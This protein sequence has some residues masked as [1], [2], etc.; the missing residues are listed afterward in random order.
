MKRNESQM[1]ESNNIVVVLFVN[2]NFGRCLRKINNLEKIMIGNE[3]MVDVCFSP[4][5][6]F[7][8]HL[9]LHH[10]HRSRLN[11]LRSLSLL[12]AQRLPYSV[13]D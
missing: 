8:W 7:Y 11:H 10:R 13:C 4:R 9:A 5:H 3:R 2:H 12:F 6:A 1:E